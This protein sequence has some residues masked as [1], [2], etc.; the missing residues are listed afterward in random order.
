M[1]ELDEQIRVRREKRER[2]RAAG[3]EAYPARAPYDLEPADVHARYG[4]RGKEDLEGA[5]VELA[6]P[7]R[8]RA[9]R[10]HGKSTFLDLH[11]GRGKLQVYLR[12][13]ELDAGSRLVLDNL[14]LGDLAAASGALMRT[15]TGELTLHGRE[16]RLLA[17]A[18]RPLP[19][20]W[21]GL[22]DLEARHR[23]RYLDLVVNPE[24]RRVF[25]ARAAIVR[26]IRDFLDR[27]GFIEVETPMM[28][29]LPT[30]AAARPFVTHHNAL[31]LDLYLRIAPELFLKRLIV[32]GF[33]RVYEINRN[34]RNEG[35]S[36]QHNPEFTMLEFYCAYADYQELMS[37]TEELLVELAQKVHGTLS[38][39]W[40]G[41]LLELAPP[42][43]R[44]TVREAI[45]KLGAVDAAQLDSA[46][47]VAAALAARGDEL[48]AGV[49]GGR[50]LAEQEGAYGR[51]LMALFEATAEEHLV[52][53]TFILDYPVEV[54]PFS[55]QRPDEPRFTE[56]F[57]LYIGGM[58]IANAFTELNDPDV[59][60]ERFLAQ[61]RARDRGDEEAHR[62]DEDYVRALEHGMPPTGGEGIG[63]DRLTMLFTDQ[64]S[65]RDVILFPLMKPQP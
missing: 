52:Q 60:A 33:H 15:R 64:Q 62:F 28:N 50:P 25:E 61:G 41:G 22:A 26:G 31:D 9:L 59:Q 5:P 1:S 11:D 54:S 39:P 20:K 23:Q 56:R 16:L 2:L 21:H 37:L 38:L 58:E 8:V 32:G 30:G 46:E 40:R 35:I 36:T 53:P 57:E 55:K 63:I 10:E 27:R 34:F 65:I 45:V 12:R 7:G 17:K 29:L 42:W 19:E 3:V 4:E 24:S 49:V 51:L 47:G 48:P 44:Y 13:D 6:V 18:L 14:D 43:A